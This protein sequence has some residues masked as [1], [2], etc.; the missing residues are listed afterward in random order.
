M[1]F[2]G[3]T[4]EY[5]L[6]SNLT[7]EDCNLLK[8][9]VV[10]GLSVFWS[11]G[12]GNILKV[13]NETINLSLNQVVFL[14]E[15]HQVEVLKLVS[16]K[17]VRFNRDFYCIRDHD[18]EV[19]CQGI[20][21]FGASRVPS[22]QIHENELEKFEILWKMFY[23]EM[24]TKDNLQI[25]MLQMMLKRMIILCTRIFKEQHEL[26]AMPSTEVD[27]IREFNVL[28]EYNYKEIRTV[29]EYAEMLHKSPKTLSNLFAQYNHKTPL[30]II[31][32]RILLEARRLLKFT[33]L[34]V[35][36]V[37][38]ELGFEDLQTFSRLFRRKESMSPKAFRKLQTSPST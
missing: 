31:Q 26:S 14:T 19:G 24:E 21:F 33:D 32:E 23:F 38:Y 6:L 12:E 10:N 2:A 35:K 29:G 25:E 34:S 30:Q 36:E 8:E 3:R 7:S 37:A 28:V 17:L 27:I 20:L 5:L 9:K 22:I 1:K 15:F 18:S 11:T 16:A 13:D 4:N